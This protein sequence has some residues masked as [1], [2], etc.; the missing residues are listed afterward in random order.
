MKQPKFEPIFQAKGVCKTFGHFTALHPLDFTLGK[1]EVRAIIGS[2]G[3]GKSTLV[4]ILTAAHRPDSG[5]ILLNNQQLS[6]HS[7]KD[8]IEAGVAC[9]YQH[10]SLAPNLSVLENLYLGR[11][12]TTWLH[13]IDKPRLQQQAEEL[14]KRYNIQLDLA[15]IVGELPTVKQKEVEILKALALEA[16]V[17]LMDEP[18]AWLSHKE[19]NRLHQIIKNL[20]K[21]GV[22]IV[23]ISHIL[24]EI[25]DICDSVSVLRDG[26]LVWQGAISDTEQAGIINLMMGKEGGDAT[27][28]FK[29]QA[30]SHKQGHNKKVML[31]TVNLSRKAE[32]SDVNLELFSGEIVCITGLIGSKRSELV[33]CL[34]GTT[35]PDSG[36]LFINEQKVTHHNPRN[37]IHQLKLAFVPEDRHK[38]GLFLTHSILE[39]L[40]L[41]ALEYT[42]PNFVL[43][44]KALAR[45]ARKHIRD[46]TILP[47]NPNTEMRN[48]SGGNQQKALIAKS[49]ATNPKII[50][51]DEPTVGVDI[52]AKNDI[53]T[54]LHQWR[55]QGAAVLVVSSDLEEVISLADK[56]AIMVKGKL[57]EIINAEEI[58][59]QKLITKMSTG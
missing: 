14:L 50:I 45:N 59:H 55:S 37:S 49:L 17:I 11:H 58:T 19:V 36:Q 4:K 46:F 24:S 54:L 2:N 56:V 21:A 26:K 48:L 47:T 22:G 30:S 3:A 13:F 28:I 51:L 32:F 44:Q 53:Y 35:R 38:D 6:V 9:I 43:N 1:G 33:N 8:F 10:S 39:N 12:P 18:T 31:R 15:T 29:N 5:Q 52:G 41:T 27:Q 40:N 7:P 57:S 42:S 20:K 23:Y 16:K 34:F 25:F